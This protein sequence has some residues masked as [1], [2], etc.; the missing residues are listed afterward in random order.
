[1]L[2]DGPG[3][4]KAVESGGAAADFV[5]KH[6]TLWRGVIQNRGDFRHF[7]EE[8]GTPAGEVVGGAYAR[9]D[10]IGDWQLGLTRGNEAADLRHQNNECRLAKIGGFPTHIGT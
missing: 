6:E 7:D 2:Y 3:D 8:S 9:K 4:G 1:M 5:Q 10:A